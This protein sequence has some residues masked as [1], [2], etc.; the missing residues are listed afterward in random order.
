M[1]TAV[2]VVVCIVC[3]LVG[4]TAG[5]LVGYGLWKLGF[6][7]IGSAVALVG[8]GVGGI[9]VLLALLSWRDR[10]GTARA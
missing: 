9:L 6:E 1:R 2:W 8:A 4:A 3:V 5:Y 10:R 7:I